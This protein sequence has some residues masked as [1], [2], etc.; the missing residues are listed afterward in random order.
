MSVVYRE[1]EIDSRREDATMPRSDRVAATVHV[2]ADDA[3]FLRALR[4][5]LPAAGF[6]SETFTGTDEFV[7]ATRSSP[8]HCLRVDIHLGIPTGCAVREQLVASGVSIPT[9]FITGYDEAATR[10]RAKN[11]GAAAYLPKP[12]EDQALISAIEGALAGA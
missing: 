8:P 12:F 11:A 6:I 5:L 9:I 7:A 10:E 4:R 3:S 2:I 1:L